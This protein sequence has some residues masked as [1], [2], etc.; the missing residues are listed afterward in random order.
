LP[1]SDLWVG[2]KVE[3]LPPMVNHLA[4]FWEPPII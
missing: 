3:H 2:A 1:L 4:L